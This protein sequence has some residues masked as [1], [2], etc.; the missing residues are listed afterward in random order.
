MLPLAHAARDLRQ[1]NLQGRMAGRLR[2]QCGLEGRGVV[3]QGPGKRCV[4]L[5]FLQMGGA[6]R[7]PA[8]VGG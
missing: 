7:A 1:G 8:S 3:T 5:G 4:G 2:V 6:G